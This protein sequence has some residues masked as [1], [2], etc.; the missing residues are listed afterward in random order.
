M[1][2]IHAGQPSSGILGTILKVCLGL[3]FVFILLAIS[4]GMTAY[5]LVPRK[6]FSK[7][8]MEVSPD[9]STAPVISGPSGPV[10][11]YD[12]QFIEAQFT[13]LQKSE[14]LYPVIERLDLTREYA[15][16]GMT[17]SKEDAFARLRRSMKLQEVRNTG[18]IEIGIYDTDPQRAA[19]IANAIAITYME[20]RKETASERNRLQVA[21]LETEIDKQ[22]TKLE[23]AASI[24]REIRARHGITDSDPERESSSIGFA[25][26]AA[27]QNDAPE[28]D[29]AP[30]I[31]AKTKMAEYVDAKRRMIKERKVLETGELAYAQTKMTLS[32][33]SG[34]AKIWE[35]A[36][37]ASQPVNQLENVIES[38]RR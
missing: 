18:L 28:T 2:N 37:S 10:R 33:R 24:T 14:I 3:V 6:Y 17:P 26:D 1:N 36:E 4:G 15:P 32:V 16:P 22:R 25:S 23:E 5:Y 20:K 38:L 30:E 13:M 27:K 9:V 34:T 35:K 21:S 29:P 7:V 31:A 11:A 12:P 8:T 19:N